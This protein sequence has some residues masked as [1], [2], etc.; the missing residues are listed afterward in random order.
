MGKF[1]RVMVVCIF[2]LAILALTFGSMLFVKREILKGRT[3]KLEQ[4]AIKI[5]RTIE[6]TPPKAPEPLNEYPS[7][8]VSDCTDEIIV[9]PIT[10]DF[11]NTYK[12]E[13]ESL[14]QELINLNKRTREL[15]SYYRV[16]P[17]TLKC[18]RDPITNAKITSGKGT[19]QGVLDDLL[20][21]AE[22]QYDL[23]NATRAQLTTIRIELVDTINE[24]NSRKLTLREKLNKIVQ[25]NA[26]I[27]R[28]NGVIAQLRNEIADLKDQIIGLENR[29]TDLEAEKRVLEEENENLELKNM[30]LQDI[31][32]ELRGE[33]DRIKAQIGDEIT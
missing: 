26:E 15:M 12:Q 10:S 4:A 11:W 16:D 1:L 30:K 17:V 23:L 22:E 21:K 3:Y 29:I 13:L 6:A 7:K 27:M 14:D 20:K 2:I 24:L 33:L 18:V 25:L 28:L 32:Q 19:T 9:N 8:D 5:A 31:V